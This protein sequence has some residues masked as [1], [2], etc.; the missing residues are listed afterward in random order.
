MLTVRIAY[1]LFTRKPKGKL[2]DFQNWS[3]MLTQRQ[4]DD[5]FRHNGAGDMLVFSA[6][7]FE[8]LSGRLRR[9]TGESAGLMELPHAYVGTGQRDPH[10]FT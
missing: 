10:D 6:A 4:G 7:D 2:A 5:Y 9:R 8:D 1:N 3:G